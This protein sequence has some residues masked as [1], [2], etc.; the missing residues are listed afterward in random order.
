MEENPETTHIQSSHRTYFPHISHRDFLN[1]TM[2]PQSSQLPYVLGEMPSNLS[3]LVC[4]GD[5][6]VT[7]M[8]LDPSFVISSWR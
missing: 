7:K 6:S 5:S 3:T 8:S 2:V 4:R 1:L